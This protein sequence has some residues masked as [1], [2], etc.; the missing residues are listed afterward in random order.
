MLTAQAAADLVVGTA[1]TARQRRRDELGTR[2]HQV[3]SAAA[4]LPDD[5]Y[6][7]PEVSRAAAEAAYAAETARLADRQTVE[8]WV[9]AATEWDKI[10][11]P[12]DAAYCRWRAAQVALA[13][14]QA[15]MATT[16]LRKARRQAREHVPLL[17]DI[18]A[19]G[20]HQERR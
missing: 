14:G 9:A 8:L 17:Q 12:H 15:T 5:C 11:R 10:R 2:L 4:D 6:G 7:T 20:E 16:L 18:A 1:H 13:T 19:T 3:R